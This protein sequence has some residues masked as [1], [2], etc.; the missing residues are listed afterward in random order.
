[1]EAEG[2]PAPEA[3]P[4]EVRHAVVA[5]H[6]RDGEEEPA[7]ARGAEAFGVGAGGRGCGGCAAEV[8]GADCGLRGGGAEAAGRGR[9]QK[10][11]LKMFS[12]N[13]VTC[14]TVI[15]QMAIVHASCPIWYL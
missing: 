11:P 3:H 6:E 1:M 8:G 9:H 10:R 14:A 15:T 12:M 5:D 13:E 2:A 4:A 7:R